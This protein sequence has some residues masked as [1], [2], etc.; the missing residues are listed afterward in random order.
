M[1]ETAGGIYFPTKDDNF[2]LENDLP[3]MSESVEE[4][5]TASKGKLLIAQNTGAA[6]WEAIKGD[7]TLSEDGTL[8]VGAG[9][10]TESKVGDGAVTSRKAKLTTFNVASTAVVETSGGIIPG[11]EVPVIKPA[12][13]G[14]I[15]AFV[16][17]PVTLGSETGGPTV[18]LEV[19]GVQFGPV[20]QGTWFT[21]GIGRSVLSGTFVIPTTVG[22]EYKLRLHCNVSPTGSA[23]SKGATLQGFLL[24]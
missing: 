21:S 22:V 12:V 23:V 6:V 19:N 24:G 8:T 15:F 18:T 14:L 7:A 11:T 1:G 3:K 4:R 17:A 20:L 13:E 10:I 9:A 2:D 16:T 5:L